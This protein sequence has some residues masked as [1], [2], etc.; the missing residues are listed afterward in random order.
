MATMEDPQSIRTLPPLT[1]PTALPW[2]PETAPA[3]WPSAV[4]RM[5][6][7]WPGLNLD[8]ASVAVER[9]LSFVPPSTVMEVGF[10][11]LGLQSS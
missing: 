7:C 10:P 1:M 9:T 11:A 3:T 4:S 8:R 6:I 5:V 2:P